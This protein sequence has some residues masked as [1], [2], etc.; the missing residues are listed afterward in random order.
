M[1]TWLQKTSDGHKGEPVVKPSKSC[2][3]TRECMQPLELWKRVVNN[4][5]RVHHNWFVKGWLPKLQNS[6]QNRIEGQLRNLETVF[7]PFSFPW[8]GNQNQN[9]KSIYIYKQFYCF[10]CLLIDA[11]LAWSNQ[12]GI[13]WIFLSCSKRRKEGIKYLRILCSASSYKFKNL[14]QILYIL[15]LFIVSGHNDVNE[16]SCPLLPSPFF[17]CLP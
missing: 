15:A 4:F 14:S 16:A 1:V 5:W 13:W 10:M 8:D 3:V 9:L 12:K 7:M 6:Q 17:S 2:H 11:D